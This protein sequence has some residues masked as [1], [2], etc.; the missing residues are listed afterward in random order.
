MRKNELIKLA[1]NLDAECVNKYYD[2]ELK[3]IAGDWPRV[4]AYSVG[5]EGQKNGL[6]FRNNK[7]GRFYYFNGH[8]MGL[9]LLGL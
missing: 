6:I 9:Y 4:I 5:S 7:T 3:E 2:H 8:H 1:C